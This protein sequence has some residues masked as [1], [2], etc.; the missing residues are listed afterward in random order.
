MS[1]LNGGNMDETAIMITTIICITLVVLVW[2]E[3]RR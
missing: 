1:E 2:I 3:K